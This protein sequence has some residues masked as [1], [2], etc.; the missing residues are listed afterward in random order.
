[1]GFQFENGQRITLINDWDDEGEVGEFL[2]TARDGACHTFGN[3]L[4]PDYNAAHADH[5]HMG[6][7]GFRLC[8]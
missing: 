1:M 2:R 4:G 6:M 7:R 8:R 3:V 5:F